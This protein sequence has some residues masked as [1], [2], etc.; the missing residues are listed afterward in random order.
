MF[1]AYNGT[2]KE[3]Q[4]KIDPLTIHNTDLLSFRAEP[5]HNYSHVF[6]CIKNIY[7]KYIMHTKQVN[8]VEKKKKSMPRE[9]TRQTKSHEGRSPRQKLKYRA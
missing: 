4:T 9:S 6:T 2:Q 1:E 8:S 7:I 3:D 5:K